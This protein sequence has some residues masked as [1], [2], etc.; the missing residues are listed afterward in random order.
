MGR[1]GLKFR[2]ISNKSPHLE[3]QL[4][5][6]TLFRTI[7]KC[8]FRSLCRVVQRP[9]PGRNQSRKSGHTSPRR[10]LVWALR[11]HRWCV[12]RLVGTGRSKSSR[13]PV[14]F[15][16]PPRAAKSPASVGRPESG[17]ILLSLVSGREKG[18]LFCRIGN[19]GRIRREG[20]EMLL[21]CCSCA[22]LVLRFTR[23]WLLLRLGEP[24][25]WGGIGRDGW[26]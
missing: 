4:D 5:K 3:S 7:T 2:I 9:H 10:L 19:G 11:K 1:C 24:I 20:E 26:P 15:L 16:D 8:F 6:Q 18:T 14:P 21:V 25:S 13:R 12:P 17:P 23:A 22:Q